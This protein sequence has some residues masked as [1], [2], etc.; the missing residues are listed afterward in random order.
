MRNRETALK[1][2]MSRVHSLALSVE[3][4]NLIRAVADGLQP[5]WRQQFL[6]SIQDNLIGISH[7]T[8]VDVMR[9]YRQRARV[10]RR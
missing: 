2:R 9:S 5:A 3:Q 6:N 4:T 1:S 8:D 7:V 10:V